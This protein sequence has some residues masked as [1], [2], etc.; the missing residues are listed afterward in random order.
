MAN[1]DPNANPSGN[2]PAAAPQ[3]TPQPAAKV[4]TDKPSIEKDRIQYAYRLGLGGLITVVALA[5]LIMVFSLM[6]F[7]DAQA[8]SSI[9]SPFLTV[10]GTMVGAFFGLQI[11]QQGTEQANQQAQSANARA[12]NAQNMAAELAAAGDPVKAQD[13][14]QRYRNLPE[15]K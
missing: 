13:I 2:T 5:I 9:I 1:P 4:T 7:K 10:L 6:G 12:D 3:E 15:S 11:G 8:V 14:V